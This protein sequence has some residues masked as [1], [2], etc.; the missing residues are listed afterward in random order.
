MRLFILRL[1]CKISCMYVNRKGIAKYIRLVE[2]ISKVNEYCVTSYLY[3]ISKISKYFTTS[4]V[5]Y[6]MLHQSILN[7]F[8]LIHSQ[9]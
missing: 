8:I 7:I 9:Y 2:L 1:I 6:M 4:V 3:R 5:M